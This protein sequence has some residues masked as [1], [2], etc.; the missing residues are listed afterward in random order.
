MLPGRLRRIV[1]LDGPG[2]SA[3][4][5]ADSLHLR[6]DARRTRQ[7]QPEDEVRSR[8]RAHNPAFIPRNHKV[9]EALS[10]ATCKGDLSVMMRLVEVLASPYDHDHDLP[11]FQQPSTARQPYRTFCGT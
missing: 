4:P 6:L 5:E 10:A 8:M 9:E 1:A 11:E 7:P 2:A 3:D